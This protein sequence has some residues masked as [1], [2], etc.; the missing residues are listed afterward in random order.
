MQ[1]KYS[2]Q[3]ATITGILTDMYSTMTEDL[4]KTNDDE[5]SK[6]RD[7]EAFVATKQEGRIE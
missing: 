5:S 1:G 7:F 2:P 3:S 4:E 6:N